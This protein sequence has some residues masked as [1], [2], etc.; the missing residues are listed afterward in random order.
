M[1]NLPVLNKF[2]IDNYGLFPGTGAKPGLHTKFAPGL[3]LVLGANGLGKTTL[4][5]ILFRMLTGPLDIPNFGSGGDLGSRRLEARTLPHLDRQ[6][7]A[8]RVSDGAAEAHAT[9]SFYLGE[10]EIQVRRSL[11]TL[12]LLA[13]TV[14][15]EDVQVS[16]EEYAELV[17]EHARLSSFGD[18]I[19]AL[20]HLTF[21]SEDRRA[22]I[23]DASAQRQL[24]RL[25]FLPPSEAAEWTSREREILE[26]DSTV[27]NRQYF[28]GREERAIARAEKSLSTAGEVRQQLKLSQQIQADEQSRLDALNDDLVTISAARETA[29]LN[30]LKDEQAYESAM[31]TFNDLSCVKSKQPSQMLLKLVSTSSAKFWQRRS[32]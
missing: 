13:L 31:R 28:L 17:Q 26:L 2:E 3:K 8:Q 27:R 29:R 7:F 4:I 1:I 20:R 9:L 15:G 11:K 21:Y 32:A 10:T 5:T 12:E 14:N 23:W 24:L 18:W 22:L 30:A 19:L 25:L 16:E 6:I